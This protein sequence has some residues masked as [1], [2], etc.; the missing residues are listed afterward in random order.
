MFW[1]GYDHIE[2][3]PINPNKYGKSQLKRQREVLNKFYDAFIEQYPE[4]TL[5]EFDGTDHWYTFKIDEVPT[6]EFCVEMID[7][8]LDNL[9]FGNGITP[10]IKRI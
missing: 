10:L 2:F 3:S 6:K 9:E 4:A 8:I 7:F 1:I 5:E